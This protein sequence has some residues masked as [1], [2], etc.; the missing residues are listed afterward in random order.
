MKGPLWY[1]GPGITSVPSGVIIRSGFASGS[2]KAGAVLRISFG[3]PVLPPEVIPFQGS[4]TVSRRASG[5]PVAGGGVQPGGRHAEPGWSAGS[6]PTMTAGRAS[7]TT[8]SSSR[9][10]NRDETG[11]GVA[12]T[13]QAA[14][15]AAR[16]STQLGRASTTMSPGP[17]P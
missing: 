12:P 4:D 2:I 5:S 14:T 8:P 11:V 13:F 15:V 16:N 1:S 17:T 10:G 6:T 9:L 3:R 7:S